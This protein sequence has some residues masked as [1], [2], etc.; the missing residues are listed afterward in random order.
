[1]AGNKKNAVVAVITLVV[2]IG[3]IFGAVYG[4]RMLWGSAVG[5]KCD[6]NF[7]CTPHS[8][9][10]SHRCR[11]SCSADADCQP[12]WSCRPTSVSITQGGDARK[13]FELS[14]VK[15]CFSPESMAQVLGRER[16][17]DIEAKKRDVRLEVIVKM[18]TT[19]PQLTDAEF[20]AAWAR[21]VDEEKA[22]A[23]VNALADRVLTIARP[24]RK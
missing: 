6:D 22:A 9:C 11:R 24:A 20:E 14:S 2:L 15:I 1:M 12:G 21:I 7:S 3:V 17:V 18:T 8:I 23:S 19:P 4:G 5:E 13:G 16:Q 10:I